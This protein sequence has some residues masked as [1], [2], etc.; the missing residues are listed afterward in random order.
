[1]L[2]NNNYRRIYRTHSS[3]VPPAFI[4]Q[5][6]IQSISYD[7]SSGYFSV[8]SL[9]DLMPGLVPFVRNGGVIRLITSVELSE[10]SV[11]IIQRGESLRDSDV[12]AEL[13]RQLNE[14]VVSNDDVYSLNLIVNLIACNR[15]QIKVAYLSD[16]I[17]HEKFGI[18]QDED[19]DRVYFSGSANATRNGMAKNRES[20]TVLT[21]W[22]DGGDDAIRDEIEYFSTIWNDGDSDLRVMP[23]PQACEERLIKT[24]RRSESIDEAIEL[25]ERNDSSQ[26]TTECKSA[27]KRLYPYQSKAINEFIANGGLHFLQMA[28]GTGK[29]F[30]SIRAMKRLKEETGALLAFVVVPQID[31][32]DQWARALKEEGVSCRLCGGY[33]SNDALDVLNDAIIDYYN[34]EELVVCVAVYRTFFEK[35][36]D[37]ICGLEGASRLI[38][39]D[40]AH[41]LSTR[42]IG[43]L[44]IVEHR[45]GLSAT[46]ERFTEYETQKI[47]SYF[48]ENRI[49]PFEFG[50]ED[51]IREGFLSRY[52]YFPISV[53][54]DEDAFKKFAAL[55]KTIAQLMNQDPVDE[56]KVNKT[57][58]NRSLLL[59]K[60]TGKLSLLESMVK[61][62]AYDFEN[63]VVYCGGGK[64]PD[65]EEP[66]INEAVRILATQ[67][68]YKVSMFTSQSEDRVQTIRE[69]ENGFFDTL[70]AI[71]CFDQGIDVP[72][73]DKIYILA[74]DSSKR[75]TIQRRGRVLR[76]CAETK[77]KYAQIFDMVVTPP[78]NAQEAWAAEALVKIEL[79]RV[80]EYGQIAE[81]SE[82]VQ[83]FISDICAEYGVEEDTF[84]S[85]TV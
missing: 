54:L 32:Q 72:K 64:D 17:Y 69:F 46:P 11:K 25:I 53:E 41:S 24:Y 14:A 80:L 77:K 9:V 15:L 31:L 57:R 62:E 3:N 74:S 33:A 35:M 23:L 61:S 48:T 42:Q 65:T 40:E 26:S 84:E 30:T 59:K 39:V 49:T 79:A 70:V 12:V 85:D 63:S 13:E 4:E 18:F 66:I 73:L 78:S 1:M 29:T 76:K 44:P 68:N 55:T 34:G 19:G 10:S 83:A 38:V 6:L 16:G 36:A 7:R 45:L 37:E 75:Q 8:A 60:A 51:A 21:S 56:E 43:Q 28:T 71:K 2:R 20:I 5:S 82:E 27:A 67:G 47:I 58:M 52:Y 22:S 81:N 50:I